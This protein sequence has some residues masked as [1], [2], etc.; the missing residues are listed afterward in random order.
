MVSGVMMFKHGVMPKWEDP[1]NKEGGEFRL[2]IGL[3]EESILQ[4]IWDFVIFGLLTGSFP[5]V[6]DGVL[7]VRFIQK[8]KLNTLGTF[9]LQVWVT[10]D[11]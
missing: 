7:G 3:K 1:V 6:E 2:E 11:K 9:I 5:R 10:N 4:K 8:Q